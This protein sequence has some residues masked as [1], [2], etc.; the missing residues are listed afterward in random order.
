MQVLG[1]LP[2][3]Y[4]NGAAVIVGAELNGFKALC[5][6]LS[7]SLLEVVVMGVRGVDPVEV[8]VSLAIE[9]IIAVS[10]NE[11][12]VTVS[13]IDVHISSRIVVCPTK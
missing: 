4:L 11:Y 9:V 3:V 8:T 7:A 5:D 6:Y 1:E 2:D 13:N 12:V 10:A